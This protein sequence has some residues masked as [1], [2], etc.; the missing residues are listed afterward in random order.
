M[1]AAHFTTLWFPACA[2]MMVKG[3]G[4]EGAG[5]YVGVCVLISVL[6]LTC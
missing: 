1:T 2:G 3:A 6:V 5:A 4:Y